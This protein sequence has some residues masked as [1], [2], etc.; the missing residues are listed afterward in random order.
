MLNQLVQQLLLTEVQA[1]EPNPFWFNFQTIAPEIEII[2]PIRDLKLSRQ[3][4]DY[5]SKRS[6]LF[7]GSTIFY[8]QRTL[9]TSVGGKETLTSNQ[10]PKWCLPSQ[11]Q[12]KEKKKCINLWKG[13]WWD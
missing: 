12:K 13:N 3:E 11:L 1:L 9:G 6:A 5:L 8:Q 4:V 2:T 7:L 10:L